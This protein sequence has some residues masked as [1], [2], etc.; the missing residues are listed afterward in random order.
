[1]KFSLQ[2]LIPVGQ[3]FEKPTS[4]VVSEGANHI[5]SM[6]GD[7]VYMVNVKVSNQLALSKANTHWF[8]EFIRT[9]DMDYAHRYWAGDAAPHGGRWEYLLDG[10][11]VISD[12]KQLEYIRSYG[13]K[14]P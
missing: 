2:W 12:P 10:E 11:I 1:M 13:S 5:K 3:N 14:L 4:L 7:Q 9:A 8:D 6:L